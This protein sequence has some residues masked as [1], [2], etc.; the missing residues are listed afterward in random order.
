MEQEQKL[1]IDEVIILVEHLVD[2]QFNIAD[3]SMGL[4]TQLLAKERDL[5]KIGVTMVEDKASV[6]ELLKHDVAF[7][8][9]LEESGYALSVAEAYVEAARAG[10]QGRGFSVVVQEVRNLAQRSAE[11]AKD[12]KALLDDSV[13]RIDAGS[14]LAAESSESLTK[15]VTLVA[16]VSAIVTEIATASNE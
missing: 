12:I 16:E 13:N 6:K 5:E 9:S 2:L 14:R 11:A 4:Q 7:L 8:Q 15:I 10:E 1:V 3:I